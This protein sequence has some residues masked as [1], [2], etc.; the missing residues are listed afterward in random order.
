M[1]KIFFTYSDRSKLTVTHKG[2]ITFEQALKYHI[3]YGL[4]ADAAVFQQ[5]PKKDNAA[6]SLEEKLKEIWN[7]EEIGTTYDDFMKSMS[8][9]SF[10]K[11][12]DELK[13]KITG[14]EKRA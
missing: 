6:V 11:A 13:E 7:A 12:L 14:K 3:R 2:C 5:Y 9:E 8:A 4:I 1:W 10:R